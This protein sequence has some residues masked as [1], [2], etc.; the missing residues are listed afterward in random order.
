MKIWLSLGSLLLA[1]AILTGAF[2]AHGLRDILDA[3]SLA[4]YEKAVWYQ[5]V[6]AFGLLI[7]SLLVKVSL[8]SEKSGYRI[9]LLLLVGI[10]LFSGS[11][12][13]LSLTGLR[14][15]GAITPFGGTAFIVAWLM[16]SYSLWKNN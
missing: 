12:Y 8:L 1:A 6:H 9:C 4:V 7:V 2:G 16:L 11:L 3:Y 14:F 13:A 10:L 15:F 5:I